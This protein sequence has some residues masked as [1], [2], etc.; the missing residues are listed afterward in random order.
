M[1]KK[2]QDLER[3]DEVKIERQREVGEKV[4]VQKGKRLDLEE[5]NPIVQ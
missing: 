5:Y 4:V 3:V 2:D 1:R